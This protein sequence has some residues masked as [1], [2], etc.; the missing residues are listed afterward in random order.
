MSNYQTALAPAAQ[1]HPLHTQ[2]RPVGFDWGFCPDP[3]DNA[4][5][6]PSTIPFGDEEREGDE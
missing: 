1:P 3:D 4:Y 2:T 6:L 5:R